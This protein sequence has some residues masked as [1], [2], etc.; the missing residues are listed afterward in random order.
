MSLVVVT[1]AAGGLGSAVC[2]EL[3]TR[4]WRVI[5]IDHNQPRLKALGQE[6]ADHPF[7]SIL[8]D[9]DS[10][11]MTNHLRNILGKD[12]DVFGFVHVAA[13]SRGDEI[14]KLSDEDWND[15]MAINVTAA[16]VLARLLAP[17]MVARGKGAIVN[18]GSPVGIVG[19]RKPSYAASKAALAGL[20]MSLAR[21][22]GPN[23]VRANLLLP[24]A[25]ITPLTEDWS[26][27]KRRSIASQSFL[28]RL[29]EPRE[30]AQVIGFLLSDAASCITGTVMDCTAGSMF[31][32]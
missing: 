11:E 8:A 16:M 1:G 7:Q 5:G 6:L 13:K 3:I 10:P 27:E 19:A 30:V 21:N 12:D 15:S 29:C 18:V 32:H 17:Y 22:L 14:C 4:N 26:E 9:I 28:K 2:R 25:M 23:G 24:G 31:S 20:T